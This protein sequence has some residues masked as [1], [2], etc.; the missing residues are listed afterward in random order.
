MK[1]SVV[2]LLNDRNPEFPQYLNDIQ[3]LLSSRNES[4]EIIVVANGT[5]S[6][7][8]EMIEN[9]LIKEGIKAFE[10]ADKASDAVCIKSVMK[11]SS[12][13]YIVACG[14][15]QQITT[16]SFHLILDSI[17]E[18]TDIVCPW[19][20]QR[21]DPLAYKI[22]SGVF[23]ALVRRLTKANIHDLSCNTKV[24]RREVVEETELYGE[25][26]RFLPVYAARKGFKC[27]EIKCT[28][29]KQKN[30]PRQGRAGIYHIPVYLNRLLDT[31][32]LYFNTV[33]ARKPLRFFISI[34]FFFML[35]GIIM[36]AWVFIQKINYNYPIGNRPSLL[37]SI[38]FMVIGIQAASVG[39]LGE[40]LVFA[41]GRKKKE[42]VIKEII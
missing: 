32:L 23:N 5:G 37:L 34:G 31:L 24:F 16:E 6:F 28:H 3:E 14:S 25:M 15:F 35:A 18:E 9:D 29:Y 21:F 20:Q 30:E 10:I 22:Q 38:F 33:F 2:F 39:L 12:G 1:Y 17:D 26:Y 19:R 40:I 8:K 4:Y 27:K 11:I 42:F 41:H 13:K 7:M 36:S